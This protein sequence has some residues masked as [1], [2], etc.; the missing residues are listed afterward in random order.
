MAEFVYW[1]EVEQ[2]EAAN[3]FVYW[4]EVENVPAPS[5]VYWAEIETA[6]ETGDRVTG[7]AELPDVTTITLTGGAT[8]LAGA[9]LDLTAAVEDQDGDPIANFTGTPA[10]DDAG[11]ATVSWLSA[12]D[13]SGQATIRATGVAGGAAAVT[14]TAGHLT[15]ISQTVTVLETT[16]VTMVVSTVKTEVGTTPTATVTVLDQ[17]GAPLSG[18]TVTWTSSNDSV[19]AD[20]AAGTTNSAGIATAALPALAAG[21]TDID[22]TVDGVSPTAITITVIAVSAP[23]TYSAT[24][25]TTVIVTAVD[26]MASW[27]RPR[28]RRFNDADQKRLH[29][30]DRFFEGFEEASEVEVLWPT[31][32]LIKRWM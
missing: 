5:V 4:S 29:P 16:T 10:S 3:A 7:T 12:T 27:E 6:E 13:S 19:I 20:P 18:R 30:T 1:S 17:N 26:R 2:H 25:A 23:D 22:V 9:T 21:T 31:K 11:V 32:E 14:F 15:S 28:I 8:I 24:G